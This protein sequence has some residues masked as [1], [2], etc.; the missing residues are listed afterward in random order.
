MPEEREEDVDIE[1]EPWEDDWRAGGRAEDCGKKAETDG[2]THT[3]T[4]HKH[5][6]YTHTHTFVKLSQLKVFK[7]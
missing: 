3:H 6:L 4:N 7:Y 5:I 1:S 2:H